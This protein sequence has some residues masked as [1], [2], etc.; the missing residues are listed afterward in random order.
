MS[1]NKH[2][3]KQD[4]LTKMVE[5]L[6]LTRSNTK[7]VEAHKKHDEEGQKVDGLKARWLMRS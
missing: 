6:A 2:T 5:W 1:R 4:A 3:N 7:M